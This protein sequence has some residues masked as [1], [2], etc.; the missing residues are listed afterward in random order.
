MAV[1]ISRVHH[2]HARRLPMHIHEA[3]YI[4]VLLTGAYRESCGRRSYEHTPL[5]AVYHPPRMAHLDEIGDHGGSFLTLEI[6][7]HLLADLQLAPLL[8][9]GYP[10]PLGEQA[11]WRALRLMR[12]END[13]S[14]IGLESAVVEMLA[15]TVAADR[16]DPA[17]GWIARV[18]ERIRETPGASPSIAELARDAGIHPVHLARTFR[19]RY[20]MSLG[21]FARRARV[22]YAAEL[23]ARGGVPLSSVA[24]LAGFADQAHLTRVFRARTGLTPGQFRTLT[25]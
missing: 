14:S 10:V 5:T 13:G 25:V 23:I 19:K 20:G 18:A 11:R 1:L 7:P 6:D 9:E 2:P 21:T 4:S 8:M 24:G 3:P 22:D 17:A 16:E 15:E 12:G